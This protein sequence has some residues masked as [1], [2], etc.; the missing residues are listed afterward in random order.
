LPIDEQR[1]GALAT[2]KS[3]YEQWRDGHGIPVLRGYH[4]PDLAVVE[5]GDWPWKGGRGAFLDLEGTDETNDSYLL[6]LGPA[7]QTPP[8]QH[9]YEEIVYVLSGRGATMVWQEG[10]EATTF[11]WAAGS[12][13]AIPLNAHYQHFNSSGTAPARFLAVTSAPLVLNLYHNL[14]FV[15]ACPFAFTDRFSGGRSAFDGEGR[16]LSQRVWDTNFV[17]DVNKLELLAWDERGAGSTNRRIELAD[18][19]L[20]A[21]VSEFEVG[22]Y[23]KAHRHGPG[24]HVI[25]LGGEGY[26]M[27]WKEGGPPE[28]F[29]WRPGT[30]I[31]PPDQWFHQHCNVGAQPAKYLA[32]RWYSQ[33]YKVFRQLAV[34][35]DVKA[36][37]AQIELADEDPSIRE[38]FEVELAQRGVRS[39]MPPVDHGGAAGRRP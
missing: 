4:I 32:I 31:V 9:V 37:G 33:K 19:S 7:G 16:A 30:L 38:M 10:S 36:G 3:T 6:E 5:L 39:A 29:D 11:E 22:K 24:A 28:R 26:T 34:D 18:S 12:L 23:K 8:L 20:C 35:R 17:A 25:M 15:F 2:G 27:M 1:L 13:F 21:H 14:E